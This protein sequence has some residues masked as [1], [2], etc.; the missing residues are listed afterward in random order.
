MHVRHP[1]VSIAGFDPLSFDVNPIHSARQLRHPV[2]LTPLSLAL[3][4]VDLIRRTA[5]PGLLIERHDLCT[6]GDARVVL[7]ATGS[8][9]IGGHPREQ[10]SEARPVNGSAIAQARN[11]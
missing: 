5:S 11:V 4:F 9:S 2:R 6:R 1:R 3:R 10:C 7:R 8:E